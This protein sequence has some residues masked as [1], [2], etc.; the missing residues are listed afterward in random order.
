MNTCTKEVFYDKLTYIFIEMPKF[1]KGP[2]ELVTLFDKWLYAIKCMAEL[3]DRPVQLREAIFRRLFEVAEVAH[4][5]PKE[6]KS[7][8]AS[9]KNFRDWYSTVETA[10]VKGREEGIEIGMEKG[11]EIGREEGKI[12]KSLEIARNLYAIGLD[13]A[14]IAAATGLTVE[15]LRRRTDATES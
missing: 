5:N 2:D 14:A 4:L 12:E 1:D 3:D 13:E 7:Y 15:E 6:I 11:K 9:L 8:N 10:E